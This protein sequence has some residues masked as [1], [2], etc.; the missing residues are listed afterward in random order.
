METNKASLSAAEMVEKIKSAKGEFIKASWKSEP[1]PAAAHKG[2]LLE[3][4][5]TGV[6]RAGINYANLSAVTEAIEN[7]ERGEVQELPFGEWVKF[8]YIIGHTNKKGEYT[9]YMRLYPS[10]GINHYPSSQ[11]FVDG[12]EVDKETFAGYLTPSAA[13]K[14]LEPTEDDRP[15]CFTIKMHNLLPL[16]L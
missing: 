16:E 13:K 8:P 1:K 7:G 3:K 6:V 14:L 4:V 15:L 2:V 9:E 12:E 5:T 11:F 10:E